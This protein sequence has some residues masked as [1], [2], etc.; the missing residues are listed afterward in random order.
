ME[1]H[2]EIE[3]TYDPDA[4]DE[5]RSSITRTRTAGIR[6][7]KITNEYEDQLKDELAELEKYLQESVG[8]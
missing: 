2:R 5:I 7:G 6:M 1:G 4:F 8:T 3:T